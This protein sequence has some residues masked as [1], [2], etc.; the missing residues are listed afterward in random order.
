M[1]LRVNVE[2]F[3]PQA[4]SLLGRGLLTDALGQSV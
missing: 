1:A 3:F 2:M 4:I